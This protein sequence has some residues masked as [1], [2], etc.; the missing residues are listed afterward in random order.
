MPGVTGVDDV[1]RAAARRQ[2]LGQRR[3]GRRLQAGP[4]TDS[5]SRFNEVG[6]G[7]FRT[8]GVPLIAGREFTRADSLGAPKVAI[9]NEAFAKKF[10]LGR[11]AVGKRIGG[12]R[13]RR[14]ARHRDRRPRAER[15]V[16]RGQ[17]RD[18]A[19][20]LPAVS[21]GRRA[22]G[23]MNFYV[24]TSLDAGA[25]PARRS[26]RSIARLDP[27]PAGREPADDAAAGAGERVP[28]SVHQ[29]RCRRRSRALATLLAAIGLYGVL[30]YTVAQRTREIGLRMALGAAPRRVR[31]MVL[32]QVGVMTLVGGV[33]GLTA[34]VWAGR[35][36]RAAVSA[37]GLGSGRA[38]RFRG[39]ADA[40]RA[41]RRLHPGAP[42][43]AGGPDAG[44]SVR[45]ADHRS[46]A[47]LASASMEFAFRSF[48]MLADAAT[49]LAGP[50]VEV[51]QAGNADR[52]NYLPRRF[53]VTCSAVAV[54]WPSSR[55]TGVG[56]PCTQRSPLAISFSTARSGAPSR[57]LRS[58]APAA[59]ASRP[60]RERRAGPANIK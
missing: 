3:R 31:G 53:R 40:R 22:I 15:E 4:D 23:S 37:P 39:R 50:G 29:R 46:C 51:L 25:V 11:D 6:A 57:P 1:A 16:Q 7:Y 44:A 27:E 24:R 45:I 8:I 17:G 32:R 10:N 30:A 58:G 56:T 49:T 55:T 47:P 52:V 41:R 21:A 43:V 26:R 28:R 14:P 33:I 35:A 5:N 13:R 2:Q 42:R 60:E 36:R 18:A 59:C 12:R 34:A 54:T 48:D 19:A 20:V 9:V 38:R